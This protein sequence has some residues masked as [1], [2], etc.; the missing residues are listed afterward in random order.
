MDGLSEA[1]QAVTALRGEHL[2]VPVTLP[3]LIAQH[4]G[5]DTGHAHLTVTGQSVP[6]PPQARLAVY[7][8]AQEALSNVR[9]HAPGATVDVRLDWCRDQVALVVEDGGP[10]PDLA[11]PSISATLHA[12]GSGYGLTGMAE[13]AQ[14]AG[15]SLTAEPTASGFRVRLTLPV[16]A[17]AL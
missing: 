1:R 15:G 17:D 5:T 10:R 2:P 14:L 8:T 4:N 3:T 9:K 6:L 16:R 13:R 12:A 11:D 7:R